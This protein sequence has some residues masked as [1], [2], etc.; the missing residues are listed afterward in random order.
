LN[1][2]GIGKPAGLHLASE[3]VEVDAENGI[4]TLQNGERHEADV[5]IAADGIHVCTK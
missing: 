3:V 4:V 1:E 2:D 5:I